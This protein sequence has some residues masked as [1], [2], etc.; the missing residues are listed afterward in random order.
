MLSAE[1]KQR[2]A[3][4][5][6]KGRQQELDFLDMLGRIDHPMPKPP[7]PRIRVQAVSHRWSPT[8]ASDAGIGRE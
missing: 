8:V 3:E 2:L 7:K 5:V 6:E 4:L 1:L